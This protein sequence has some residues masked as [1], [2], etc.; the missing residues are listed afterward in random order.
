[1]RLTIRRE[2]GSDVERMTI[3]RRT[4]R[5]RVMS[6]SRAKTFSILEM[7]FSGGEMGK[8]IHLKKEKYCFFYSAPYKINIDS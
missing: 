5:E 2:T 1:M 7:G 6:S 8:I 3:Q 4:G